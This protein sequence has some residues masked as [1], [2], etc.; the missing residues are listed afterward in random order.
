MRRQAVGPHHKDLQK[1][2]FFFESDRG[3]DKSQINFT[4][5]RFTRTDLLESMIPTVDN[6]LVPD[7]SS[8]PALLPCIF[9]SSHH[10]GALSASSTCICCL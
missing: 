6:G 10:T 7:F 8:S 9:P 1:L 5:L 4:P 3:F 2:G